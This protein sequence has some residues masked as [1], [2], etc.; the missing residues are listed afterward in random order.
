M[1]VNSTWHCNV[2]YNA[3]LSAFIVQLWALCVLTGKHTY[4]G[5]LLDG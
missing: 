4:A 5:L 3:A 1:P 2:Q